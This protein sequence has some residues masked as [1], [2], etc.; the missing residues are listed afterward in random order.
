MAP[1]SRGPG[2]LSRH[3]FQAPVWLYRLGLGRLLGHRFL[4]IVHRG[5]KTGKR[6]RTAVEVVK[7]DERTREAFVVSAYGVRSDWYRNVVHSPPLSVGIGGK[8][9][10]P[11]VRVVP[12]GE[13]RSVLAEYYSA[14][15]TDAKY[16]AKYFLH[17]DDSE[18]GFLAAAGALPMLA[19]RP[20]P[21]VL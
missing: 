12:P 14:H 21:G 9:F 10:A 16:L 15:A 2:Q 18:A 5:R 11:E 6:R 13:E 4:I 19:F 1:S 17:S 3:L 7:Y 8:W 20:R